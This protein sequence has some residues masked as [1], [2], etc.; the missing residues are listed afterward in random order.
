[1]RDNEFELGMHSY[2]R[3]FDIGVLTVLSVHDLAVLNVLKVLVSPLF[4]ESQPRPYPNN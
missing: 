1:M 4:R 3:Y 2:I